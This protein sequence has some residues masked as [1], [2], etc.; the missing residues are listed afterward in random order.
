MSERLERRIAI[1]CVALGLALAVASPASAQRPEAEVRGQVLDGDGNPLQGVKVTFTNPAQSRVYDAT[2][3][4]KGRYYMTGL[5]YNEAHKDWQAAVEL[6]GWM[7]VSVDITSRTPSLVVD[8]FESKVGTNGKI[9]VFRIGAIGQ[10]IMDVVMRPAE[11]VLVE[12]APVATIVPEAGGP[13]PAVPGAPPPQKPL[14]AAN[15]KFAAGDLE[16]A[17][18]LYEKAIE[19]EPD[20]AEAHRRLAQVLYQLERFAPAAKAAAAAAELEPE[21]LDAQMVLYSVYVAT[22]NLTAAKVALERAR[23]IDPD[24]RKVLEQGAYLAERSGDTG[25]AIEAYEAITAVAPDDINAWTSLGSLY[26]EAGDS[27][28]SQEAYRKVVELKPDEAY[29]I[30]YNIGALIM[31]RGDASEA[32]QRKAIDAFRKAIEIKPD[33]A[34][35][36]RQLAFALLGVGDLEGAADAFERYLQLAPKADDAAMVRSLLDGIKSK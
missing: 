3:N 33:Y 34:K 18:P 15:A 17:V 27:K 16:A 12:T 19:S 5:L 14:D 4:K 22:D 9:P 8:K 32:E 10:V 26:A 28:R 29:Q 21:S 23:E 24:N 35:A 6:E 13:P 11:E 31:N 2:T 25:A 20:N 30:F 1:V 7:P 36:H